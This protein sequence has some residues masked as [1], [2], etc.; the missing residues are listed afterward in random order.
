MPLTLHAAGPACVSPAIGKVHR[1]L[2]PVL[3]KKKTAALL[4]SLKIK[5]DGHKEVRFLSQD[6]QRAPEGT[7]KS[8]MSPKLYFLNPAFEGQQ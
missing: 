6:A 8:R 4:L 7:C 3:L 1:A 5:E 2:V